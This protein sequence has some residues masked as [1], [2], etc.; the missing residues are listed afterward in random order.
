M[1]RSDDAGFL[2]LIG[3]RQEKYRLDLAWQVETFHDV[4]LSESAE[5]ILDSL[6]ASQAGEHLVWRFCGGQYFKTYK[7]AA[8]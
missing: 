7:L 2:F 6:A 5:G 4:V 1:L 8:S 3:I